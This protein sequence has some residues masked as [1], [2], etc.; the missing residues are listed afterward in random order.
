MSNITEWIKYE[1]YPSLY[2]HIDQALPEFQFKRK[3]ENWISSNK[4]KITGETGDSKGKVYIWVNAPFYIKDFT[5]EPESKSIIDYIIDKEGKSFI[6]AVDYLAKIAGLQLPTDPN[7]N[8]AKYQERKDKEILLEQCND[9]FKHCLQTSTTANQTKEYLASRGYTEQDI[10]AM[11][12][13]YI[14][15]QEKLYGYLKNRGYSQENIDK[16]INLKR[17]TRIGSSH[18]LT[19]PYRSGGTI[20]GFKFRTTGDTT[21]KYLNSYGL[22]KGESLF[23][24]KGIRGDKDLIIVEGELDSLHATAKGLDN[25]VALAGSSL[26]EK[27][28]KDA[29]RRGAGSFTICLDREPGKESKTVSTVYNVIRVIQKE[30]VNRVYIATL[31]D[32]GNGK[33]DPDRLVK[34][35]GIEA[36]KEVIDQAQPYYKYLLLGTIEKYPDPM[37]E[38]DIESLIGE[39]LGFAVDIEDPID[40]DRYKTLFIESYARGLGIGPEAIDETIKKLDQEKEKS[41]Q[42]RRLRDLYIQG[43]DL[44]NQ[45]KVFE[46]LELVLNGVKEIKKT[47]NASEY[48]SLLIPAKESE[49][50]E[51]LASREDSLSSGYMIDKEELLL[52]SGA[53]SIIASPTSHGKTSFLINTALNLAENYPA[54]EIYLFSYEED[55]DTII[56]NAFNTFINDEIDRYNNRRALKNYYRTG[57][58]KYISHSL[59]ESGMFEQKRNDFFKELI[60][61]RRLNITYGSYNS[62]ELI[63]AINY[64][65]KNANPGAVL[66]DYVQLLNLPAG[67]YKTNSRQEELK[68]VCLALKDLA[69]ETGLPIILGSQF[70]RKVTSPLK[71]HSTKLGEAGDIERVANVILGLWNGSFKAID[72]N[73][74]EDKAIGEILQKDTLYAE[75]LKNRGGKVGPHCLLDFN[76]N[77]GK[78]K[79]REKRNVF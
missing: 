55:Q 2:D 38:K 22:P 3:G 35:K 13:G 70:N 24:L 32:L 68:E 63:G 52:P 10:E 45:G 50:K 66:I 28:V 64:L 18:S 21:P 39:L 41:Q 19:I 34:E 8:P 25:V 60:E 1:L 42:D 79:N 47:S 11:D 30:N 27:Q 46:A 20:K 74:E 36:L 61:T 44:Q 57:D 40:R 17:D 33:T 77:T 6:E 29:I 4:L 53:I 54:K 51:R 59:I 37:T 23:N 26:T 65:Y 62:E 67:K 7:F 9:Y 72:T 58:N 49:I 12:L 76:G 16:A 73:A 75:I 15:S 56:L 31:P 5:R 69:V 43:T 14:P 48:D 71:L 78:I